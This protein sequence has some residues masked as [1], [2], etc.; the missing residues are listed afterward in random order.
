M[1]VFFFSIMVFF[2][3]DILDIKIS[4]SKPFNEKGIV[5]IYLDKK[6]TEAQ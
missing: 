3:R 1:V 2:E 6:V 5:F 4:K